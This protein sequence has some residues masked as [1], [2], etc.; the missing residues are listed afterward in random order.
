MKKLFTMGIEKTS[1]QN[2]LQSAQEAQNRVKQCEE[3]IKLQTIHT[4]ELKEENDS[5]FKRFQDLV[6]ESTDKT[7]RVLKI[8]LEMA[9]YKSKSAELQKQQKAEILLTREQLADQQVLT[10]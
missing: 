1:L 10:Q 6:L 5:L 8:E 3:V 2:K 7:K 4:K 9:D